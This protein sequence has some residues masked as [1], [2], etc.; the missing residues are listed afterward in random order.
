MKPL[1]KTRGIL[2]HKPKMNGGNIRHV[3]LG[4]LLLLWQST[5]FAQ[6]TTAVKGRVT[7]EKGEPLPG[8]SVKI[9]SAPGGTT[10]DENGNFQLNAPGNASLIFSYVGYVAQTIA[11][12]NQSS[13]SV[14]LMV[15]NAGTNLDEVVV[16]G[17]GTQK[18]SDI[19]G[20]VASV[21]KSR[22][23]QLP[24]T[25]VM[26]AVQGAVAGVN[27]SQPSS[28]PGSVP[29]TIVRGQNSI[30]ANSG[31]YIV[32]DGIPLSKT[33]GSLNDINPN[34]IESMEILKDASA[35]AIYGTNGS[36][37]VILIT[38][39]RGTTG[40]P[41]IR[42]SGNAGVEEFANVLEPRSPEEFTAKYVEWLRQ[43][44]QEWPHEVPVK[45]F[46]EI[47]NYEA[48]I[49]TDWMDVVS[50]TGVF[51]DHNLNISGGTDNVK[52]FVSG[53]L[54]DQKGVLKGYQYRRAS[55]R[56]NL[57]INVTDF[58]TVGASA[59][60]T[61]NNYDGGRVN[62]LNA[63]AM[64]PYG[65]VYN[66][67]GTYKIMPMDPEQLYLNPL[68][69]L[70]TDRIDRNTNL[71]G[72]GYAEVKFSGALEGL[73]YRMNVG[74]TFLPK[75][76][77]SYVGREAYDLRGTAETFSSETH[78]YTLE[79]VLSYSKDWGKHHLDV[80]ALYSAQERNYLEST[81]RAVGFVNDELSFYNLSAG[82][83]QETR[84]YKDRHALVSQMGR[85]NYGY[86][87]RYLFTLTGRRDGSSVFG[88]N[89]SKYGFF[90][91]AAFAWNVM[92]ES[93]MESADWVDN[94]K[95][96][97]SYGKSGNEAIDVYRT[98]TTSNTNRFPFNGIATI[99]TVAGNLGNRNL[100][101]ESSLNK[102][103]GIDFGILGNRVS[104]TV[105]IY[106]TNTS[107]LLLDRALP[108]LT[109]YSTVIDNLGKTRNRGIELTLNTRNVQNTDFQWEST[110]VFAANKNE[111]RELY[112]DGRD[113]LG[114]RWFL[115]QPIQVVYDY[116]MIGIWQEGED[117]STLDPGA[118]AGH[119]KF[120]DL[121]NDGVITP[122]GDREIIGQTAPKWTGG[123]TN[124]FHY[125]N[126]N[127]SVFIQTV[128]GVTRNNPD[129]AYGDQAGNRNTPRDIGYWTPENA[130]NEWPSLE[131]RNVRGYGF[132]QDASFTR[133]KDATLSYVFPRK[134][135]EKIKVNGLTLYVSGR[136]LYTFTNW[137]GWDPET[138]HDTRGSGN[139]ATN[140]PLTRSFVFGVNVSL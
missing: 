29:S 116:R 61:N 62:L 138:V 25:N 73:K 64:S 90:P 18:R 124:T 30:R 33:G 57:D 16:V 113:D 117:W 136:N 13:L 38:T 112:G 129:I 39:K 54:M 14:S 110:I 21:P 23:S 46:G 81:A 50:Q 122:E 137:I 96:R 114:N 108:I 4:L 34:D 43:T 10:T 75:R 52:Y 76:T 84:S 88:G 121:D 125:K 95:L 107:D 126:W 97:L 123:F 15:D 78:S 20:S 103:L 37:G 3:L 101:W 66:A 12:N 70:T 53:G 105:D 69:G 63:T 87:S 119:V 9:K 48:G 7:D 127:L 86:D 44:N 134:V 133:I 93:F 128:Q 72:N 24:V 5:V 132:A 6:Q 31:P 8:V 40:K 71:N 11:I 32:V 89:T 41:T 104:G 131:Y 109:G 26:Q 135:L 85:I 2:C 140:Y 74:Y 79:N 118:Q 130:S 111:I 47:E 120:A 42:Y 83:T 27:V 99:G 139:W 115:G 58:L 91:S 49:H 60:V 45:N 67:D 65:Q 35:V 82:A 28:V 1:T 92:N 22:L 94:L 106:E 36:Q 19:T 17:Y 100:L 59:F 51:Q 77:G 68:L 55:F 80:T 98:I 56:S 102:N